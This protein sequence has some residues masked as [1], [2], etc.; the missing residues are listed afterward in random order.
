MCSGLLRFV[1]LWLYYEYLIDSCDSFNHIIQGCFTGTGICG[2]GV[3]HI[4]YNVVHDIGQIHAA[5]N[6][7]ENRMIF[8]RWYD[9]K[10]QDYVYVKWEY[11][12]TM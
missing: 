12:S 1:L 4:L 7:F 8:R 5:F 9:R 11:W 3:D 10:F 2:F 6:Y